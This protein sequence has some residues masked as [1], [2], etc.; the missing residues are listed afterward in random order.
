MFQGKRILMVSQ[1]AGI[2]GGVERHI[3]DM[4]NL[5]RHHG[6]EVWGSFREDGRDKETFLTAFDHVCEPGELPDGPFSLACIQKVMD[7]TFLR[8][9]LQKYGENAAVWMHDH[10]YYCPPWMQ[11]LPVQ[12]PKLLPKVPLLLLSLLRHDKGPATMARRIPRRTR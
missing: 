5:L 11:V 2:T 7:Q 8:R 9:F 10:E 4:A 12:P 1:T 6:A 3:Y